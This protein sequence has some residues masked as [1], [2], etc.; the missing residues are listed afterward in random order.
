VIGK[1]PNSKKKNY[2]FIK[3]GAVIFV[4]AVE[5]DDDSNRP[6]IN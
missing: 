2:I 3:S 6:T 4:A 1:I 5:T